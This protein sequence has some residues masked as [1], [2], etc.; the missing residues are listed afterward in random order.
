MNIGKEAR[1]DYQAHAISLASLCQLHYH[2]GLVIL[3]E[4][5]HRRQV[6]I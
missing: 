4:S 5:A 1:S 6:L 2:S 3:G